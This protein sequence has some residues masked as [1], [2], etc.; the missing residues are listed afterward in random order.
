MNVG[1]LMQYTH[2]S[3]PDL[4]GSADEV[5]EVRGGGG[6]VCNARRFEW[7]TRITWGVASHGV[8]SCGI[9]S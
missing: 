4:K 2:V 9:A 5:A 8:A 1:S 6:D 7:G 3:V